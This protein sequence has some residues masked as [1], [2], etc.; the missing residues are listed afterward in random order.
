MNA[1]DGEKTRRWIAPVFWETTEQDAQDATSPLTTVRERVSEGF[2]CESHCDEHLPASFMRYLTRGCKRNRSMGKT[3]SRTKHVE[4]LRQI[5]LWVEEKRARI[6][7]AGKISREAMRSLLPEQSDVFSVSCFFV[8][9]KGSRRFVLLR[10]GGQ[11]P[12]SVACSLK[13]SQ[14]T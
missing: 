5:Y 6:L 1:G 8:K 4:T 3:G 12:N 7:P 10:P 11:L 13:T 9:C 14:A 2:S